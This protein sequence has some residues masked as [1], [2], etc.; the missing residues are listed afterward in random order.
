MRFLRLPA[1]LLAVISLP[2]R[3]ESVT[4]DR[5]ATGYDL[6]SE[7][8]WRLADGLI[9]PQTIEKELAGG[10]KPCSDDRWY[11]ETTGR[12]L[13]GTVVG[14]NG[15]VTYCRVFD[16]EKTP[17]QPMAVNLSEIDD[18]DRAFING[19]PVGSTGDFQ[20]AEAQAYDRTRLYLFNGDVLRRGTNVIVVHVSG[21]S[22]SSR[23]GMIN[24]RTRIGP[25]ELLLKEHDRLNFTQLFLL[26]VY[27]TVGAYFLFLFVNR[28]RDRENLFFALFALALVLYQ[29]LRTQI[30]YDLFDSFF[31]LKRIEYIALMTLVP[32]FYLFFRSYFTVLESRARLIL[33]TG[34]AIAI[35]VSAACIIAYLVSPDP[36]FWSSVNK[37]FY[38]LG[39]APLAML[40][41]VALLG[42][43]AFQKNRDAIIM[44]TGLIVLMAAMVVDSLS[45]FGYIN[46]A[47][48]GTYAFFIFVVN[49]ALILANRFVRL[50]TEVEDLNQ[51]LERK[52]EQRT[53]EL[54]LT[55]KEVQ[56]LK[57][58]Q[59]GD[60]FLTSLLISPLARTDVR[61]ERID[62]QVLTRQKKAFTFN[63]RQSEIGGDISIAERIH[64]QSHPYIVYINADAMGKSIQGAGGALVIGTVFRALLARTQNTDEF[65][66]LPPELWLKEA[67]RE[68]QDVFCTFD[69]SML[70]SASIGLID[71]RGIL[72][73]FNAEHP[74]T[75][76][77]RRAQASFVDA[78]PMFFKFG[79]DIVRES[80]SVLVQPL[81]PGDV[82][83]L[84]TDGRD[85]IMLTEGINTDQDLFLRHVEKGDGNLADII[86]SIRDSGELTDDLSLLRIAFAGNTS[87]HD[88]KTDSAYNRNK[89]L[90]FIEIA[91]YDKAISLL[92][93]AVDENPV[94]TESLYW[95]SYLQRK[96]AKRRK[97]L[98]KAVQTGERVHIRRPDD[99]RNLINLMVCYRRLGSPAA[100][101]IAEKIVALDPSSTKARRL[102]R[103]VHEE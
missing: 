23:W 87:R 92:E 70:L 47:R 13:P 14:K 91:E 37:T 3:A 62:V 67:Y 49:L 98:E 42:Y 50:H 34:G 43:H 8:Y 100:T 69:G 46:V 2:L 30:K 26:T 57:E 59:D 78:D 56:T 36:L 35:G 58:K 102:L 90:K 65:R 31:I 17:E 9:D 96:L 80:F 44:M 5:L 88:A 48:I 71:E 21:F 20:N 94:D 18:R 33:N 24:E 19:V 40:Q 89:A 76:L 32:L 97:D 72:Y 54:Q 74:R 4:A 1:L 45:T 82:L 79:I 16:L 41:I 101:I 68:I 103:F 39:A 38:L 6:H 27:A 51:N 55:L 12:A 28:R 95:L 60:Y 99:V 93:A 7:P 86:R 75:V 85:D 77:Y 66:N 61:S 53:E 81:E 73:S 25:A 15:T 84:G 63:R 52:V 10:N 11:V 29:F 83:I 64:L 22:L